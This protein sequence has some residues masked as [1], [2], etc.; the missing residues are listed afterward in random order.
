V[1]DQFGE[2]D[3]ISSSDLRDA[4]TAIEEAPWGDWYG[5]PLSSRTL[6]R[7]LKPYGIHTRS[8]RRD[9]GTTPK[10]FFREQFESAFSRYL[11][12]NTPSIRHTATTRTTSGIEPNPH[13]PQTPLVADMKSGANP[14]HERVVADVADRDGGG[15]LATPD[16]ESEADRIAAKWGESE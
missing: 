13:P 14:H 7:L 8:V 4:L 3:R 6:A 12:P 5:K 16:E 1:R 15:G 11:P 9:D 2:Q 10:G